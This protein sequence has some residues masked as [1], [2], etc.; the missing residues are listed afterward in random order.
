MVPCEILVVEDEKVVSK[1]VQET[2]N[3]L[4][5]GVKGT[6]TSGEEAVRKAAELKPDLI[7]MDIVLPGVLDGIQAAEQIVK[8]HDIPIVYMTAL[9]DSRTVQRAKQGAPYG[10]VHKPVRDQELH[11][12]IEVAISR[13]AMERRVRESQQWLAA[14]L[15]CISEAV[16]ATDPQG[17]VKFM[18]AMAEALTD[19]K[20]DDA[21]GESVARVMH[22]FDPTSSQPVENFAQRYLR[23]EAG[24][25]YHRFLFKREDKESTVGCA[26][27]PI[28]DDRKKTLGFVLVFREAGQ[29]RIAVKG[30][31]NSG[32]PG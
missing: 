30:D 9:A 12:A 20:Q 5:Y 18:S 11:S 14:T 15:R 24:F 32:A 27:S 7:L 2:L 26:V 16:V 29:L 3:R 1:A 25:S 31:K 28:K 21:L 23:E 17:R 6:A 22:L 19:T 13:Q 4:G 10:Y 8:Y